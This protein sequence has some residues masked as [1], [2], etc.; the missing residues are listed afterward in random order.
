MTATLEINLPDSVKLS[1]FDLK[2]TLAAKMYEDGTLSGGQAANL[3]GVSKREFLESLGKYGVSIFGYS[4]DEL[5]DD[6]G[7][8]A[9]H[10]RIAITESLAGSLRPDGK[11]VPMTREEDRELIEEYLAEKH[12]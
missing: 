8:V 6:M 10:E 12:S 5:E 3:A 9:I 11:Y 7:E 4:L 1:D 2:M